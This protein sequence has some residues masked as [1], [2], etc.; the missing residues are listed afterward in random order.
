MAFFVYI[1]LL[2]RFLIFFLNN[3]LKEL[4][5]KF[6]LEELFT[7]FH[8]KEF[9][10]PFTESADSFL[11]ASNSNNPGNNSNDNGSNTNNG[12]SDSNEEYDSDISEPLSDT[13]SVRGTSRVMDALDRLDKARKGDPEAK[14]DIEEKHLEGEPTNQENLDEL[15]KFME[16][17]YRIQ[18]GKEQHLL[19]KKDKESV[20]NDTPLDSTDTRK[21]GLSNLV[22]QVLRISDDIDNIKDELANLD[23]AEKSTNK[24]NEYE[25]FLTEHYGD[26]SYNNIRAH[27]KDE[28]ERLEEAK[29]NYKAEIAEAESSEDDMEVDSLTENK[30]KESA[31][32]DTNPSKRKKSSNNDD[33][34]SGPSAPFGTSSSSNEPDVGNP[35]SGG[36]NTSKMTEKLLVI[37]GSI[38]AGLSDFFDNFF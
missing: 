8:L 33:D 1:C 3:K 29:K 5:T 22:K 15:E 21:P 26:E 23:R 6:H 32:E 35:E 11:F 14:K 31:T 37:L 36:N 18:H 30:R 24:D 13:D 12:G 4:F 17:S 19:E 20:G 34:S 16:D 9:L 28:L 25:K 38:I 2:L 7:K 10:I 27:L